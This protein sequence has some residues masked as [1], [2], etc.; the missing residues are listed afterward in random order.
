[1]ACLP[2]A[3]C[4]MQAVE[5]VLVEC[6]HDID[7]AIRRLT[8]LK[9]GTA[10][11]GASQQA[12]AASQDTVH[13]ADS[14]Q[15]QA[16]GS[17]SSG[18]PATAEQWVGALVQ[19]MAS[20]KDFADARA[21][22]AKLLQAF[23]Q[24]VLGRNKQQASGGGVVSQPKV[25]DVLR[26]NAIL[27]RAVQIQNAKLQEAASTKDQEVAG[28]KQLLGQYQERLRHLE[29]SNYSLALHLQKATGDRP[30]GGGLS[31]RPPDVF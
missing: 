15:Q 1:M 27:K 4:A 31:H 9:L 20:A 25:E 2:N 24:F 14:A 7:A 17:S 13:P 22:A 3:A 5:T 28:L 6:G 11:Q 19:E 23:E 8:E 21:R 18:T 16:A 30:P 10:E 12:G 29:L 26:E